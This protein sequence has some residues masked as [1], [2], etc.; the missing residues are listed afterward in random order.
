[1]IMYL[2]DT[3]VIK[4]AGYIV[5]V[6]TKSPIVTDCRIHFIIERSI[7]KSY[8]SVLLESDLDRV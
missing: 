3:L 6:R 7:R 5:G 1:M 4:A 2:S 8:C